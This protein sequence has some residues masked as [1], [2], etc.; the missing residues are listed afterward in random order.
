MTQQGLQQAAVRESTGTSLSYDGDWHTIFDNHGIAAGPFNGRLLTYLQ[1]ALNSTS[2]SLP[3]LKQRYAELH[4]AHNESSL[5]GLVPTFDFM[6]GV[7]DSRV[8][9]NRA[10]GGTYRN[11][12]GALQAAANNT[13]R[14]DHDA[15]GNALGLLV[16]GARTNLFLRSEEL[17]TGAVWV[18]QNA[19]VTANDRSAPDGETT[20]E[21]IVEDA[22]PSD[23]HGVVQGIT[24][25]ASSLG[26]AFSLFWNRDER[27]DCELWLTNAAV[28]AG[29][30][31]AANLLA[32]TIGN[33]VTFGV[34]FAAGTS[35]IEEWTSNWYRASFSAT[36]DTD[37]TLFGFPLLSDGSNSTYNGD[38]SSGA[39]AWGSQ[40]EQADFA[41]SYISTV[42]SSASRAADI[43]T[44]AVDAGSVGTMLVL[45]RTA[46]G[47]GSDAQVC[48]Q[49]DDGT[50]D[51]RLRVERNSS[52]E[53]RVIVTDGGVEQA[54]L[55]MGVVADSTVFLLA[56][57]WAANDIAAS[58]GG[59]SVVSDSS[60]TI[61]TGLD[62]L[63]F[64]R[65]TA[66]E[67]WFGHQ[68][69]LHPFPIAVTDAELQAL[70]Q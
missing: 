49:W 37:T 55:N 56:F 39:H 38:G 4:G 15:N 52:R 2:D 10:S 64:G 44:A 3:G 24:K 5:N 27:D 60:A 69:R 35:R 42:A 61:P 9:L 45:A 59:G 28:S 22:T 7:L 54:N 12:S 51:A 17:N 47:V 48:V 40:V 6:G 13:A 67:E 66:G 20:A 18:P 11:S 8:T 16:E 32:G 23:L 50:E 43:P 34:G 62:T 36:S 46:P 1:R 70:S 63:R 19:S 57:R 58:L 33:P 21:K 41:S 25:A 29:A 53:I 30:I 31:A 68:Q 65:D 26:Y 14:F